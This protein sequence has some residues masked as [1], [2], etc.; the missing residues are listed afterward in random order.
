MNRGVSRRR[1]TSLRAM[2]LDVFTPTFRS[3][4]TP[5]AVARH[6]VKL[7]GKRNFTVA[8]P[9]APVTALGCQNAVSRK[10][11]L[12]IGWTWSP[13]FLK[14]ANWYDG[15]FAARFIGLSPA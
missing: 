1:I 11:F 7:S 2:T 4:V 9:S 12:I 6:V 14:S 3:L 5:R 13:E 8:R 10:S 15:L